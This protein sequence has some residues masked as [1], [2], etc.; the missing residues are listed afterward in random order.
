[1]RIPAFYEKFNDFFR[2]SLKNIRTRYLLILSPIFFI[3]IIYAAIIYNSKLK[4]QSMVSITSFLSNNNTI[5]L[6]NY[7]LNQ[8]K[9]PYLEY[10]YFIAAD[11]FVYIGDLSKIFKLI[12]D[13]NKRNGSFIFT[14]EHT[15]RKKYFITKKGRYC[16][17]I[18]YIK[19]LCKKFDYEL[20][21]F[22]KVTCLF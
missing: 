20:L 14:T 3:L 5:L 15:N 8:I 11:V 9:S 12:K 13:R 7:L 17:S 10:D 4:E 2:K 19:S 18:D 16:H 6:K 22:R 21:L 1:M